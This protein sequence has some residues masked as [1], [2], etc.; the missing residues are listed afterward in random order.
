VYVFI[1]KLICDWPR[2]LHDDPGADALQQEQRHRR[3]VEVMDPD[4]W[5]GCGRQKRLEVLRDV[6]RIER[7]AELEAVFMQRTG[8]TLP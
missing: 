8:P 5:Q 3:V 2:G 6:G 1:V 7:R 4:G